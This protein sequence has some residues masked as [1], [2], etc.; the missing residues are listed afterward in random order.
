MNNNSELI[1]M[2]T[3]ND[4]TVQ[5]AFDIF[6]SCKDTKVKY[7]GFKEE[8]IPLYEMKRLCSF[9]KE[10]G[11]TTFIEVVAYTEEEC[12]KGVQMAIDCNCDYIMGTLFFDSVN[13]L[14]KKNNVKYMP[15]VGQIEGRPSILKGTPEEMIKEANEYLAKGVYGFDLLGYRYINNAYSLNKEFVSSIN[16][17]VCIAGSINSFERIDEV[18]EVNPWAF[19]IGSAFF[20]NK[21][22]GTFKEQVN[23]VY[24]YVKQK[25]M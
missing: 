8:G 23:K 24:K 10:C 25:K 2:L 16:A 22:D 20:D 15:F 1:V 21:F 5:N 3:Y 18:K 14:C 11:K 17:P 13:E 7:W 9:M 6:D 12:L 4:L 19:T